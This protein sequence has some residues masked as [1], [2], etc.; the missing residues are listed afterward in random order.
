M[1]WHNCDGANLTLQDPKLTFLDN[2]SAVRIANSVLAATITVSSNRPGTTGP[3]LPEAR[4]IGVRRNCL[5]DVQVAFFSTRR[6]SDE[7]SGDLNTSA[8]D[9]AHIMMD[10]ISSLT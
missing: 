7:G 8:I 3:P 1:Q 4:A 5:V 10:K 2:T 6:P 9:I